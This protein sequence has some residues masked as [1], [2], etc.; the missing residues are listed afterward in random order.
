MVL[1]ID[2]DGQIRLKRVGEHDG[3]FSFVSSTFESATFRM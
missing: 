2:A 3:H 1:D